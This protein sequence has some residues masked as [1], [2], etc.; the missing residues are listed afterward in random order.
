MRLP[1][2]SQT[3]AG[4][5]QA[6]S[7][8]APVSRTPPATTPAHRPAKSAA[9]R[10]RPTYNPRAL[11]DNDDAVIMPAAIPTGEKSTKKK[12]GDAAVILNMNSIAASGDR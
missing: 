1:I 11:L 3:L 12:S 4:K 5:F 8:A 7:T 2:V 6:I 10:P 9:G